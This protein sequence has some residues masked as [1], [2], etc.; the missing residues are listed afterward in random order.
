[1]FDDL[2]E[3]IGQL[4]EAGVSVPIESDDKGYQ[5]KHL[6]RLGVTHIDALFAMNFDE[7]HASGFVDFLKQK[8]TVGCIYGNPSV[9]PEVVRLLKTN[10][11]MGPGITALTN[12]IALRRQADL[13]EALPQI[14]GLEIRVCWN[15]YPRFEDE[16]NLSLVLELR[17]SLASA[18]S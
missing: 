12:E 4:S 6:R 2:A 7:D 17:E 14:S 15:E 18:S 10:D 3:C 1:M 5:G 8:I 13:H 11:G 16:N 9:P